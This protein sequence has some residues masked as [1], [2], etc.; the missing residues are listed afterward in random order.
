MRRACIIAFL[1]WGGLGFAVAQSD[2]ERAVK[3]RI[4]ALEQLWYQAFKTKDMR[5]IDS[6]LDSSVLMVNQDGSVQT[7]GDFLTGM[8]TRF[9]RPALFQIQV[10]AE[11]M[12]IKVFGKTAIATGVY[13]A[14]GIENGKLFQRRERFLD[15]WKYKD[16]KWKM[17]GA[18]ATTVLH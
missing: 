16:G 11:S 1:I 6:I 4:A 17:I 18:E 2:A 7:K 5:A 15:I 14:K 13:R 8:K 12:N 10:T 9:A 3:V